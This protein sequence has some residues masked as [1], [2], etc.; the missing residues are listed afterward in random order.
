MGRLTGGSGIFS[1]PTFAVWKALPVARQRPTSPSEDLDIDHH[2]PRPDDEPMDA[3]HGMTQVT[4]AAI[5]LGVSIAV[6]FAMLEVSRRVLDLV[7]SDF[8]EKAKA[9]GGFADRA[10]LMT[11]FD[12]YEY[13]EGRKS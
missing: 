4:A 5:F 10:E 7:G 3:W 11:M 2:L 9:D 8:F 13:D 6:G 1:T 12:F